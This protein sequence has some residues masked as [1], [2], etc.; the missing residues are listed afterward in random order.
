MHI[1]LIRHGESLGN[2]THTY[3]GHT[4][5]DLS[6]KGYIQAE[7]ACK[8]ILNNLK[9]DKIYSSDLIRAYN[10]V[11]PVAKELNLDIIADKDLREINAGFWENK[12]YD[13][14]IENFRETY[15]L[16]LTDIG[17]A[18][19]DGGESVKDLQNRFMKKLEEI[20]LANPDKNVLIG[21]HATPIRIT[22]CT[23]SGHDLSE[24]HNVPWAYN[25]SLTH[26]EYTD[27]KFKLIEYGLSSYLGDLANPLSK[28]V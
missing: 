3:L 11:L 14:L 7:L 17:N 22:N 10:T 16:W 28:K 20:A 19:C 4:D 25:A 18:K 24:M 1:Y 9:I 26:I 13:Y 15:N 2:K 5:L 21:T 23:V 12:K 27:G 8:Y 6:E